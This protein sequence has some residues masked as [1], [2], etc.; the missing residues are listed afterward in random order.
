M[1]S[2]HVKLPQQKLYN[3]PTG[4]YIE[5]VHRPVQLDKR[6][7]IGSSKFPQTFFGKL[8]CGKDPQL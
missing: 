6:N 5:T 4:L 7:N 1:G 3:R 2:F 8:S